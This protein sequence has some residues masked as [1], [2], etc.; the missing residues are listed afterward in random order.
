MGR[1]SMG[2]SADVAGACGLTNPHNPGPPLR[3]SLG[4]RH[5]LIYD[6]GACAGLR[7]DEALKLTPGNLPVQDLTPPTVDSQIGCG[8][9]R[10]RETPEV[11]SIPAFEKE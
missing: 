9:H 7:V 1:K 5:R 4:E 6:L 3:G 2:G 11:Y 10:N 8:V